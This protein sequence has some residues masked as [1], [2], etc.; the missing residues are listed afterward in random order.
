MSIK[1]LPGA[2]FAGRYRIENLLGRGGM[3]EVYRAFDEEVGD[4]VALKLLPHAEGEALERFRREVR[5]ARRIAHPNVARMFDLGSFEVLRFLTMELVDGMDLRALLRSR[6]ALP[7]GEAIGI[8]RQIAEGLG[9]AHAAGVVHRD[10]KPGNV[11]V[12]RSTGRV[13]VTD[14]GVARPA[15]AEESLTSGVV[16]TPAYMAPEQLSRAA[17]RRSDLYALGIILFE[18]RAGSRPRW[19]ADGEDDLLLRLTAA[20]PALPAAVSVPRAIADLIRRLLAADPRERPGAA[21]DV[22]AVLSGAPG[23][24]ATVVLPAAAADTVAEPRSASRIRVC[25]LVVLPFAQRGDKENEIGETLAEELTDVLARVAG[26]HVVRGRASAGP[27]GGGP[28][29]IGRALG[30]EN[31]VSGTVQ[32]RGNA[33]RVS[34]RLTESS[35]GVQRW[36]EKFEGELDELF[37][38]EERMAQRVAEALRLELSLTSHAQRISPRAVELY[39]SARRKLARTLIRGPEGALEL[40]RQA[41]AMEPG[42]RPIAALLAT[43]CVRSCYLSPQESSRLLAEASRALGSV[44]DDDDLPEVWLAAGQLAAQSG[45]YV[46]TVR[47]LRRVLAAAQTNAEGQAYLGALQCQAGNPQ[48]GLRRLELAASLSPEA[49]LPYAEMLYV[50]ALLDRPEEAKRCLQV[51]RDRAQLTGTRGI[52]FFHDLRYAAWIDDRQKIEELRPAAVFSLEQFP[53]YS[54]P[55]RVF[56]G[57]QDLAEVE[58]QMAALRNAIDNPRFLSWLDQLMVEA[59]AYR[60]SLPLAFKFLSD[61]ADRTLVDLLWLKNAR[62]LDPLREM[63]GFSEIGRK[64]ERRADALLDV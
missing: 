6:G 21:A 47:Y 55:I 27:D 58:A 39:M 34:V 62:L 1:P 54:V 35:S 31:V 5:L 45:D 22:L 38:F 60:T 12:E 8:A 3:G 4:W 43:T 40:L 44:D 20:P 19:G 57:D 7:L 48:E 64:V 2:R 25:S 36:T 56:L 14:F 17:D 26:L 50:H 46:T 49:I 63:P 53:A 23:A 11:L 42:C 24:E 41:L 13:V 9:A 59:L 16:G 61:A 30:V 33:L 37:E 51:L 18:M 15:I 28:E 10:L 52:V 29:V 32:K